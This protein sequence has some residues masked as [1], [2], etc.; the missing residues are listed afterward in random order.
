MSTVALER[1]LVIPTPVFHSLGYFQ[2][3]TQ[4]LLPQWEELL[5]GPQAS[6]LPRG[7]MEADP[8]Y[9]QIIPYVVFRHLGPAGEISLFKYRRGS[10]QG[11]RRLHQ[12][13]SI[14]VGGHISL[15]DH[16]ESGWQ[17]YA[18]GL[19]RELDEE[20]TID[21]PYTS[22]LV[23]MINDDETDVGRV[24][25]GVV[26]IYDVVNP[27]VHPREAE[28]H[29]AGFARLEALWRNVDQMESWSRICL[30]AIF[31]PS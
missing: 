17:T 1:V 4:E 16:R 8:S 12:K 18:E 9:K 14:G 13:L 10:G 29:D 15:D 19:R 26:H 7:E 3:L 27:R 5:S 20:V 30:T 28:M 31:A 6:Y 2:G 25:L 11:E 23:G 21:T 22:R 24:H